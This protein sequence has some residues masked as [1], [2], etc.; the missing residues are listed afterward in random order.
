MALVTVRILE[1]W[2]GYREGSVLTVTEKTYY[3]ART[4]GVRMNIIAGT[5]EPEPLDLERLHDRP[6]NIDE[7][8]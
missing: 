7:E 4:S 2:N 3:Q 5:A 1:P 6:F 8:E